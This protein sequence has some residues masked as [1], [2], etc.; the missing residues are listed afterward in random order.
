[1]THSVRRFLVH[2]LVA[3]FLYA[4]FLFLFRKLVAEAN[5]HMIL[6]GE[7]ASVSFRDVTFLEIRQQ[8]NG[9]ASSFVG[10]VLFWLGSYV[11]PGGEV[12]YGRYWKSTIMALVPVGVYFLGVLRL[13]WSRLGAVFSAIVIGLLPGLLLYSWDA[14][15]IGLEVAVGLLGLICAY[16][17]GYWAFLVSGFLLSA[18]AHAYPSGVSFLAGAAV[19]ILQRY[20]QEICSRKDR[21]VLLVFVGVLAFTL[22]IPK[23]WWTHSAPLFRGGGRPEPEQF[24]N[25]LL[26]L[27]GYLFEN[28]AGY[29]YFSTVPAL[30]H[31]A[32]GI[33]ALIGVI[34]SLRSWDK[35]LP[36][37]AI[38]LTSAL[39]YGVA[40]GVPGIRRALPLVFCAGIF[41]G[42]AINAL[43]GSPW[44][45]KKG[46]AAR[47][48]GVMLFLVVAGFLVTGYRHVMRDLRH[49]TGFDSQF[50]FKRLEGLNM[51]E[52]IDHI[53]AERR[54]PDALQTEYELDR[55]LTI[56]HVI[57]M[58]RRGKKDGF[59]TVDLIRQVLHR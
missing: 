2:A 16:S 33:L 30:L 55:M 21:V 56:L 44:T 27:K 49:N 6:N 25:H 4:L 47:A 42:V 57:E 53:L 34:V 43:V 39:I 23:I 50:L 11:S 36:I 18:A 45:G 12:F 32:L 1:M 14:I 17:G 51:V 26:E 59:Y 3:A 22:L 5:S 40:G 24:V 20:F 41:V 13:H 48:T 15:E 28:A 19:F 29:Y 38:G 37:Y 54:S 35:Y 46:A 10:H 7:E 8:H 9:Y 58:H 31:P 52:T